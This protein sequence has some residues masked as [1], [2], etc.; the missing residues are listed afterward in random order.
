MPYILVHN[1]PKKSY[2]PKNR[3]LLK[4]AL[5][6][7]VKKIKIE[8]AVKK[9]ETGQLNRLIQRLIKKLARINGYNLALQTEIKETN[10]IF[11]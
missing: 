6:A 8:I 11:K 5:V 7:R 2:S 3:V 1:T 4:I 10:Q 9:D